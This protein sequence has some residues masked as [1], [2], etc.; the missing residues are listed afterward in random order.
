MTYQNI[1]SG[2]KFIP[3]HYFSRPTISEI[4][5]A[6]FKKINYQWNGPNGA[7]VLASFL[8]Y[9]ENTKDNIA[10]YDQRIN[11]TYF[12]FKDVDGNVVEVNLDFDDNKL[13]IVILTKDGIT[14]VYQCLNDT[15]KKC[16]FL[17]LIALYYKTNETQITR[18]L[19]NS[20][21][22]A[23]FSRSIEEV[24]INIIRG[25]NKDLNHFILNR[26]YSMFNEISSLE[27][28]HDITKIYEILY[29]QNEAELFADVVEISDYDP[30]EWSDP[31]IE[32]WNKKHKGF[33]A[34]FQN[35]DLIYYQETRLV[36]PGYFLTFI[37]EL[38]DEQYVYS[39]DTSTVPEDKLPI[40][41]DEVEK[42]TKLQEAQVDKISKSLKK[43]NSQ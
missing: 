10:I 9:V 2:P 25:E 1:K 41:N 4:N 18:C 11:K 8:S 37:A 38:K 31:E 22:S 15:N 35:G 21:F 12:K 17:N 16:I 36:D 33:I 42:F 5:T 7:R 28:L 14:E 24:R 34:K 39:C 20:F 40:I 23:Q 27:S 13:P 6:L 43:Q 32:W 3:W 26:E 30:A 29:S 19:K